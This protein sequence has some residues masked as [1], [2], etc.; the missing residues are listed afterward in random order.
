LNDSE[1]VRPSMPAGLRSRQ[2]QHRDWE[3]FLLPQ[4]FLIFVIESFER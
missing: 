1:V 2:D 3:E 4:E